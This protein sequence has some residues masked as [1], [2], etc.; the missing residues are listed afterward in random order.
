MKVIKHNVQEENITYAYDL[1]NKLRNGTRVFGK[2]AEGLKKTLRKLEE[3]KPE[4]DSYDSI[5]YNLIDPEYVSESIKLKEGIKGETILAEYFEKIIRLDPKLSDLIVFASLG[6]E[7]KEA[8]LGYIPD[9]DFLCVYG[10]HL[11]AVDAKNI[12]T[13]A[14]SYVAVGEDGLYDVTKEE[15][16]ILIEVKP[17]THYWETVTTTEYNS[18]PIS[19]EG[20]V[21]IVN[22]TGC[23]IVKNAD[24]VQ[25]DIKPIHI[26]ELDD[27]L[28]HWVQDK[29]PTFD[30]ELLCVIGQKQIWEERSS[31]DLSY[32]KRIFDV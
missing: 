18:E 16:K 10:N 32:G 20:C 6:D 26:S 7:S 9:T 24:W 4:E 1:L 15:P 25:S 22:K 21:C 14:H 23:N 13:K 29:E 28:Q 19:C 31:I 2:P 11:L 12:K 5:D 27:Y 17:S 8:E 3:K 30:L